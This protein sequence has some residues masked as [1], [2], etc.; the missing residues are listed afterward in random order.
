MSVHKVLHDSGFDSVR[1][2]FSRGE[3][4]ASKG[5][6]PGSSTRRIVYGQARFLRVTRLALSQRCSQGH[7][8]VRGLWQQVDSVLRPPPNI[9][10]DSGVCAKKTTPADK[11]TLGHS[12]LKTLNQVLDCSFCC[13]GPG[14]R[15]RDVFVHRHRFFPR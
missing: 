3:T 9:T 11:T 12:A 5:N 15:K 10:R 7:V 4:P 6:S 1:T 14:S 2:F 8:V 13:Y